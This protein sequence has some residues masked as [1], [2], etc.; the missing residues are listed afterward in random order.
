MLDGYIRTLGIRYIRHDFNIDP[1]PYWDRN[2]TEDRRGI[3]QIRHIEG[4]YQL[5]DWIREHHPATVL[6][7]CA[8]GGRRVDLETARRFHTFWI[9]DQTVDPDIVRFHLE[10]MNYFLPGSYGYVCYSL[11]LPIQKQFQPTNFG[12]QS[13]FGEGFGTGGRIDNWPASMKEMARR[14][15]GVFKSI[16]KFLER[17]YYPLTPQ[18]R[19]VYSW[20]AWQFHDPDTDAGFVQVFRVESAEESKHFALKALDPRTSYQFSD[21]YSGKKSQMSGA[22]AISEG[23]QFR[24]PRLSSQI[25]TYTRMKGSALAVGAT[26]DSA[27]QG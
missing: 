12:F 23:L 24:A 20:E 5:I 14:H 10:G 25:L 13:F 21:P 16:R 4:F 17:D 7:G 1:L 27:K 19:D 9:S 22:I 11:P 6:E 8:S 18:P 15:V 26:G 2:D 3:T